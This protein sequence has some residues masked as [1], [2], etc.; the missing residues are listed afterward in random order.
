MGAGDVSAKQAKSGTCWGHFGD[1]VWQ[2][3]RTLSGDPATLAVPTGPIL[4]E[5][6]K[7]HRVRAVAYL[8]HVLKP[9]RLPVGDDPAGQLEHGEIV[10]SDS[11]PAHE[12][13]T[14]PVVRAVGALDDPA[15][16]LSANTSE[17]RLLSS[18]TDVRDDPTTANGSF[19][20]RIVVALVQA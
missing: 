17:E 2:M 11:L 16:R 12:E 1:I 3:A 4:Q 14:K 8:E 13:P 18:S 5:I 7:R 20:V 19:R 9:P 15:P 10:G 6:G